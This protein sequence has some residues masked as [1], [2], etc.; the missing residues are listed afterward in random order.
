[1]FELFSYNPGAAMAGLIAL[2]C[3]TIWP[4]FKTRSSMLFINLCAGL[5][6][7]AHYWLL[8]LAAP[9]LVNVLGSVQTGAALFSERNR[10]VNKLGYA[11]IPLMVLVGF[12]FWMGPISILCVTASALIAFGR[13]QTNQIA[14]RGLILSGCALWIVHDY[15]IGSWIA[16]TADVLS[17]IIGCFAIMKIMDINISLDFRTKLRE[18]F[19][20]NIPV[21]TA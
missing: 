19:G 14:L 1:M 18:G 9:S 5:G 12:H 8:G 7:S 4:L 16:L 3:L 11:L 17:F 6:F 15:I 10:Y 2:T 21:Q 13:M 20:F